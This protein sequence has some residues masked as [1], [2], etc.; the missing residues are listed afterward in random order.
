MMFLAIGGLVL[1]LCFSASLSASETAFF[2]LSRPTLSLYQKSSDPRLKQI[3]SLV[4]QPRDLLVTLL[5]LNVA[6]NLLVQN[7]VS[8]LFDDGGSWWYKV[9][10]PLALTLVF[11]EV[12]P[13][14][15]ALP[16]N[17]KVAHL[18]APFIGAVFRFVQPI[19]RPIIRM[20]GWISRAIFFFLREEEETSPE[21]LEHMLEA[22]KKEETLLGRECD[23]VSGMLELQRS[24]VKE[25]MRPRE[26]IHFYEVHEPIAELER[27][28]VD[29]EITRVPVCRGVFEKAL[30]ILTAAVYFLHQ[31]KVKQGEDILPFLEPISYVPE[32]TQA[33]AFLRTFKGKLALVV[34]EYGS[35][36]GLISKEDLMEKVVGEISDRRD[37]DQERLYTRI[38]KGEILAQGKL[39]LSDFE[40]LFEV[41][42][43]KES[44]AVTLGGWLIEQLGEIPPAGT[45]YFFGPF[46]FYVVAAD[47]HRIRQ[48]YV[49]KIG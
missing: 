22:A 15:I 17:T 42:W 38:G 8:T 47:P 27:L 29:L 1:L 45:K 16:L 11:G 20:T 23:F 12:L 36:S 39:E 2:S 49:R 5:I 25:H 10:V 37:L 34:D 46:L 30:G 4:K 28:F 32:T 7:I 19:R 24:T 18:A 33:W 31:E 40:T 44:S 43:K 6:A 41:D 3:G 9:G 48:I 14:S 26:E 35:I 13:K 21:A